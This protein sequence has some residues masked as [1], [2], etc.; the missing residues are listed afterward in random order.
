MK[1]IQFIKLLEQNISGHSK[2]EKKEI[3]SLIVAIT[4]N[5]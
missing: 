4:A 3:Q 1:T 2:K 5:R